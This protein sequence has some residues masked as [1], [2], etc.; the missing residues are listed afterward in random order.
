[1]P[2]DIEVEPLTMLIRGCQNQTRATRVRAFLA[3]T[4]VEVLVSIV[5]LA[6]IIAGVCYGYAEA[7][8]IAIWDSMSQAAESY[9]VEGM[10]QARTAYWNPWSYDTNTGVG[11]PDEIPAGTVYVQQDLLDIPMKGLPYST[12][13]G[14]AFTNYTFF[15]TNYIYVTTVSNYGASYALTTHLRQIKSMV[16]WTFPLSGKGYTNTILTLRASDQ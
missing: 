12:N 13:A 9:A 7:N 5:L 11:T 6:M 16:C 4:L 15:A 10:E 3:F 2:L 1:M 8:R 14:N